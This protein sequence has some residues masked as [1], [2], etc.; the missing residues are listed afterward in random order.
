MNLSSLLF[1]FGGVIFLISGL[2]G[3]IIGIRQ[4]RTK[5]QIN[6]PTYW[7]SRASRLILLGYIFL[8][9]FIVLLLSSF[10][11][12]NATLKI[13][14]LSVGIVLGIIS[15]PLMVRGLSKYLPHD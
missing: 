9:L 8:F 1:I 13:V 14:V 12:H 3:V 5:A 11:I 10:I 7:R 15:I 6:F 4:R 2:F